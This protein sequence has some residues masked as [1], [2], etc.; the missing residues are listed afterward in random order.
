MNVWITERSG[1]VLI[2]YRNGLSIRYLYSDKMRQNFISK[3]GRM[4]VQ[5]AIY[6]G[7]RIILKFLNLPQFLRYEPNFHTKVN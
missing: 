3:F 2:S 4:I 5:N 7:I 6:I 1:Y